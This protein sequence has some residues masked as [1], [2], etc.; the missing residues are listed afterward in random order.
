M[1]KNQDDVYFITGDNA[2]EIKASDLGIKTIFWRDDNY[3]HFFLE[4]TKEK[5]KTLDLEVLFDNRKNCSNHYTY[6][7]Y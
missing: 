2:P 4:S 6:S 7:N 5:P 3:V 1:E